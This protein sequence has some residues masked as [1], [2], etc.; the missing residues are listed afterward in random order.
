MKAS[1]VGPSSAVLLEVTRSIFALDSIM[2]CMTMNNYQ[3]S[4]CGRTPRLGIAM[5]KSGIELCRIK[6][7]TNH[8]AGRPI[9]CWS[10]HNAKQI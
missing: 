10:I 4:H 8:Y 9:S 3:Y 6:D 7:T 2:I 1:V 5:N